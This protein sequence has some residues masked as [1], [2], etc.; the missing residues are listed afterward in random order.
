MGGGQVIPDKQAAEELR[1]ARAQMKALRE[2]NANLE[3]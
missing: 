3:K 1:E 2:Y